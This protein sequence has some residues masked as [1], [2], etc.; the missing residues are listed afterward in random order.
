MAKKINNPFREARNLNEFFKMLRAELTSLRGKKFRYW[1]WR[2]IGVRNT[3]RGPELV[4]VLDADITKTVDR[5]KWRVELDWY[6]LAESTKF[7]VLEWKGY[8]LFRVVHHA[9][10]ARPFSRAIRACILLKHL[11]AIKKMWMHNKR[12]EERRGKAVPKDKEFKL[13]LDQLYSIQ[14]K[15]DARRVEVLA[16]FDGT[17]K[18]FDLNTGKAQK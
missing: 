7:G 5:A 4:F 15:L 18:I 16:K 2:V 3:L 17:N 8:N 6:E 1:Y 12:L 10:H 11:P 13:L 9:K 14:E